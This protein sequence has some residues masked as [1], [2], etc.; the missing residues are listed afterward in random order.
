MHEYAKYAFFCLKN[1]FLGISDILKNVYIFT[2]NFFGRGSVLAPR[3]AENSNN[4]FIMHNY[5]KYAF[6]LKLTK[7]NLL[8][9]YI[10]W[11]MY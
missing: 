3:E 2:L 9:F 10:T 8:A 4:A 6:L 11:C 1:N 5:Q 7:T